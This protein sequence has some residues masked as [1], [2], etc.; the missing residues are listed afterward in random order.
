M[1]ITKKR[2]Y[3]ILEPAYKGDIKSKIFDLSI[4]ILIYL[5]VFM[6]ILE[7]FSDLEITYQG[8]F[9]KFEFVSI[10]I[11]TI[12]FILRIITAECRYPHL[13][14]FKSI[15]KHLTSPLALIDLIAIIPFY[16]PMLFIVDLRVLRVLR[17]TRLLRILKIN[18]YT[19]SMKLLFVV[20][21]KK[22]EE[23]LLTI[24]VTIFMLLTASSIMFYL[25]NEAQ[26]EMFP[27]ILASFWWAIATLTTVGYGDVYPV[28]VLGKLLSGVIALLGIGFVA[29]PT[30]IISS[31][32]MEELSK[33][34]DVNHKSVRKFHRRKAFSSKQGLKRSRKL[35]KKKAG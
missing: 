2:I 16:L 33:E 17:V 31:G 27:N 19:N 22:K 9:R 29:L 20:I 1:K 34:G 24:F 13:S 28:T 6:V 15:I 5:N 30:G 4:L 12:E 32:F 3:T 18:R 26:P 14:R 35:G 25:E 21:K 11:F 7:S 10:I 8:I 23:L